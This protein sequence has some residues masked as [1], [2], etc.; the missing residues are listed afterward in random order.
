[1]PSDSLVTLFHFDV[2]AG[3]MITLVSFI[4]LIV[5]LFAVRYMQGDSQYYKFFA[6]LGLL[7]LSVI[8][9]AASDH[10]LIF[11]AAWGI[12]NLLLVRLM[13]HKPIWK[14]ATH[15]GWL[16]GKAFMIGF[17]CLSSAFVLL[18]YRT[19]QTSI[20]AILHSLDVTSPVSIIAMTL[21]VV[22][23]ISQSAIWPFHRWLISS[24]NSPTPVSAIMHAGLVNGGG[25]L[26][27]RFAYLYFSSTTILTIIFILGLVTA[28][29][30]TLWKLMQNDIKRMLACST[31]GQMG[32]MFAQCG[33]GL[34][35]AAVVHLCWHGL[36]KANLF[37]VSN[38][39]VQEKRLS[40]VSLPT[41][42]GFLLA[43]LCGI[44]GSYL[45]SLASHIPW[46]TTD[47]T[48]ILL[49]V[50]LI[51]A[52]QFAL[53]LLQSTPWIKLPMTILLTGLMC[54]LY[55]YSVHIVEFILSP[56]DLTHPQALNAFH[57][58]GLILLITLWIIM[59]FKD[60]LVRHNRLSKLLPMLYV[61]ALNASQ[62]HP[63]T[64]TSHRNQ[65]RYDRG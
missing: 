37:L 35:P 41:A 48:F 47:T 20:Q 30:G 22:A 15:S 9:M 50:V 64:I 31:M 12:S 17:I 45:F 8:I 52:V 40:S 5:G 59:L 60:R 56:L 18:Y 51:T 33:L 28:L 43:F 4:G 34:F 55:G 19:H 46:F 39:V 54:V 14:A 2:L 57:Y 13:I 23:A 49:S 27:V 44:S 21:I 25:F 61:K 38:S 26:L 7:V 1:M 11:L 32:F 36:F 42:T 10:L 29:V 62:P 53:T 65:Y 16:A 6:S 63:S 24:L 3:I 58:I